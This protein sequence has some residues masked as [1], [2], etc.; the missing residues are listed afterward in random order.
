MTLPEAGVSLE[1]VEKE[2]ILRALQKHGWNQSCAAR[3]L[4]ITR[5]TLLYRMEKHHIARPG[6]RAQPSEEEKE[7]HQ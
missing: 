4:G 6:S 3:Y 2:L 5:H 7:E 1:G